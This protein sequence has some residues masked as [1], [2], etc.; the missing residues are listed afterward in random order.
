MSSPPPIPSK[1]VAVYD[2]LSCEIFF[3]D[4]TP[5][6]L[7]A[8]QDCNIHLGSKHFSGCRI[9]LSRS[10]KELELTRE[11][12]SP[13]LE[14]NGQEFQGGLIP[15]HNEF[16][17]VIGNAAFFLIRTGEDA[18]EWAE[19]MKKADQKSWLL[20][21][22]EGGQ[23][24]YN[25]WYAKGRP[26][27]YPSLHLTQNHSMADLLQEI[28]KRNWKD[29]TGNVYH[30]I[31]KSG[32]YANQFLSLAKPEDLPD[33]GEH[34]CLRCWMRFDTGNILAIHPSEL[35]DGDK[36]LGEDENK[37]FAPSKFDRNG[38]PL[39]TDGRPCPRLACPHCRGELPPNFLQKPPY[40]LSIV[41]ESSSGKSYF[42]TVAINQLQQNL[43]RGLGVSF[44]DGDTKGNAALSRMIARLF[45]P[46]DDPK[47]TYLIKTQLAGAT[48]KEFMRYG[49]KVRLPAP[50][51]Y[52]LT[53]RD[54]GA[55]SIVFYDN[56]GEH[57]RPS[58]SDEDKSNYTDHISWASGILFLFD[59]LQHRKL[60]TK[61]DSK[62][63]PQVEKTLKF[64]ALK[65]FDQHVILAE[66]HER[67]KNNHHMMLGENIDIPLAIVVG[68]HDLLEEMLPRRELKND[69]FKNG[70]ISRETIDWN[71]DKAYSFLDE[72]CPEVVS[73]AE[74]ISKK[75]KYFPASSFGMPAIEIDVI[76]DDKGMADCGPQPS[77]MHPYLVEA[78][79][80]WLL[81]EIE[82][83]LLPIR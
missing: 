70:A 16:S 58:L 77:R 36:G 8:A 5:L 47:Q 59:P 7:G 50:F 23:E 79:L 2:C 64:A 9:K 6:V 74:T 56:A 57:F 63:D 49:K 45:T 66:I 78:P 62:L 34:R 54:E 3:L 68:K 73:A 31:A 18:R 28:G 44:T 29:Q 38:I 60:L 83:D 81:S 24:V 82:P 51:T 76:K 52:N 37:R 75:I 17:L 30:D 65:Q 13:R 53:K 35:G 12:G 22:I 15:Y 11:L 61:I 25:D 4:R 80:L 71:S 39:T 46:T 43:R 26:H 32:F 14:I 40:M 19:K 10:G 41:G 27:E 55:A 42:L 21:I 69:L 1:Q 33:A 67:I 48:Y 20:Y 72:F